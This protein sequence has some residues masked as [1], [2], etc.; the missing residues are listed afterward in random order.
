M[1]QN[2]TLGTVLVT[3]SSGTTGRRLTEL[4]RQGGHDVRA[5]SRTSE[6]RFDWLDRSTWEPTLKGV[7]ALYLLP[8]DPEPLTADFVRA[9]VDLGVRRIVLLS[10]RGVDVP[11]YGGEGNEAVAH[12]L[13]GEEAVRTSGAEWTILRPGWFAQNLSVGFLRE[14]VVAGE[15]RLADGDVPVAFVDA[16]DISAVA[17]EALTGSGH[18]G[19]VYELTGPRALTLDEVAE[20]ISAGTGRSVRHVRLTPE[21]FVAEKVTQGM[22]EE[23]ARGYE[24][25]LSP[26]RLGL[27][28]HV[29]DGVRLALGRPPRPF[30]AFVEDA[31]ASGAWNR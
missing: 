21:E 9:A 25:V 18:S 20:A 8:Y 2:T 30:S 3:G 24:A 19:Q 6:H 23:D 4:L 28:S 7:D 26:I 17:A 29:S 10:G 12:H 11:G 16:E 14:D 13:A 1:T 5:A 31:E 27:D 22:S 15:L